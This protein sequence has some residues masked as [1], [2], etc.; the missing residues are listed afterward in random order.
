MINPYA[1]DLNYVTV[2]GVASPGRARIQGA[3]AEYNWE[4]RQGYGLSGATVVFR[5]RALSAPTLYIDMWTP[6]H[7]VEWEVF[8]KLLE[9]PK[10]L[11]MPLALGISHPLLDDLGISSLVVKKRG[12]IEINPNGIWTAPIELLEYRKPIPRI[13]KPRG[14][15]P[16]ADAGASPAKT[17]ADKALVEAQK[18]YNEAKA[19]AAAP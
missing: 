18:A 13:V 15:V 17:E 1:F 12:Q 14:A 19:A 4:I 3:G 16:A 2:N 8:K 5:G 10:P 11:G 7:F 6:D 9:P